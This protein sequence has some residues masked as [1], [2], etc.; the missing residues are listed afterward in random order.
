MINFAAN[1]LIMKKTIYALLITSS[2]LLMVSCGGKDKGDDM[3]HMDDE[4]MSMTEQ[5]PY[6]LASYS[7]SDSSKNFG[8]TIS[9]E[10]GINIKN[11]VADETKANGYEGKVTGTVTSVCQN[12]GCWMTLDAGNGQTVMV[13]FKDY[14]F[15]VPKDI[16]GKTV[17]LEGKS[18]VRTISVD[19]QKHLAADAGKAQ[20]EIDA[21]TQPKQELRFEADGVAIK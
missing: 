14:G 11:L 19:E 17:T 20:S 15:F 4:D 16:S 13:T 3:D 12:K 9:S 18:E 1:T 5:N 7:A 8:K 2:I 6:Q 21:I 10:G